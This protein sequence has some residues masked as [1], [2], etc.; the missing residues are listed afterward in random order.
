M[1]V[2]PA[3][4]AGILFILV[5]SYIL[6]KFFFASYFE[7]FDAAYFAALRLCDSKYEK[8]LD[9][10]NTNSYCTT[11]LNNCVKKLI[12]PSVSN[13][14]PL[15]SH[16]TSMGSSAVS[17]LDYTKKI[18]CQN[19][20]DECKKK[21]LESECIL[22]KKECEKDTIQNV[23]CKE[24]FMECINDGDSLE[25][26]GEKLEKC[27]KNQYDPDTVLGR[28]SIDSKG[29]LNNEILQNKLTRLD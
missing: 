23:I 14:T 13:K 7:G 25:V 3:A 1:K 6:Y 10:G 16:E 28:S 5:A 22:L 8:C 2:S 26:C 27:K 18:Y 20:Y 12:N 24:N 9:K 29:L 15:S 4:I 17:A 19:D 21:K 11:N